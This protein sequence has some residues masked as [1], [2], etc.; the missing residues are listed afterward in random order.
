[1]KFGFGEWLLVLFNTLYIAAFGLYYVSIKNYEFLWYVAVL[2]FFFTLI[3]TT[4]SKSN[5]NQFIL[6]CLSIWGLLHMAGGGIPV[7]DSVL[8]AYQV[9]P[10]FNGTGDFVLIK[11]DQLVHVFGF[12]VTTLVAFHLLRPYLNNKTRWSVVY[13]LLVLIGMGAGSLNEIVEFIAVV[14]F[15]ETGVGGYANTLLDLV[16]NTIGAILAIG[17]IH[18]R[19]RD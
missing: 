10:L 14:I 5:F 15:S 17:V 19:R 3:L 2:V 16:S 11:F 6:W 8:Y 7:G 12:F 13:A 9:L 4:L 18:F 1:M